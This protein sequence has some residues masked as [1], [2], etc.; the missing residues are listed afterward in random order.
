MAKPTHQAKGKSRP[1]DSK[2]RCKKPPPLLD[3]DLLARL[4]TIRLPLEVEQPT[5]I[6]RQHIAFIYPDFWQGRTPSERKEC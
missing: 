5:M 6:A 2:G 3:E 4:A 1:R